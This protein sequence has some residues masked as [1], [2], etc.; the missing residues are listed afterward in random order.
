M[1][2]KADEL[3]AK[4]EEKGKEG[5]LDAVTQ[6]MQE[7]DGLMLQLES[8]D[9]QVK[10]V[11]A[12]E[13]KM[14]EAE[15]RCCGPC[16]ALVTHPKFDYY[17]GIVIVANVMVMSV[18]HYEQPEYFTFFLNWI[19]LGFTGFFVLEAILK[20]MGLGCYQYWASG[21]NKFDAFV[22]LVSMGSL[23]ME[24]FNTLPITFNPTLLRIL[25]VFRVTRL[26]RM[27][28]VSLGLQVSPGPCVHTYMARGWGA[29]GGP[30]CMGWYVC[31]LGAIFH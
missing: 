12:E 9:L 14:A 21:W 31:L 20:L 7:V 27:F 6:I 11:V 15:G 1:E 10:N 17:V 29:A 2:A 23:Y 13:L 30:L 19:N 3:K 28:N 5:D 25:R 8:E 22:V 24:M 18:E 26:I 16:H 4:A